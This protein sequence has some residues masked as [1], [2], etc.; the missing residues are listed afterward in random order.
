MRSYPRPRSR[1]R[2]RGKV[3]LALTGIAVTLAVAACGGSSSSSSG[4]TAAAYVKSACGTLATWKSDV[5]AAAA[6]LSTA[7]SAAKSL[8][9]G[10]AEYV[11]FVTSLVTATSKA[12]G[13]LKS[14]GIPN[15]KD[16]KQAAQTLSQAFTQ[17]ST[18]LAGT[19]AKAK[20]IPTTSAAAYQAAA[21]GV[22]NQFKSSLNALAS[23]S[24]K[25][26]DQLR[27]AAAKD[28]T[29]RALNTG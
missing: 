19:I 21:S 15:V 13:G 26:N 18:S 27:A 16:G 4:V 22:S 5:T 2:S 28:P 6:K 1:S 9:Q 14:A 10:K 23:A 12:A 20:A 3:R 8:A 11:V 24:P 7:G 17:A 25:S 29:C